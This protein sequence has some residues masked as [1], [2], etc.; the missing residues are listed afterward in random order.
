MTRLPV[1]LAGANTAA[2]LVHGHLEALWR[3]RT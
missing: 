1:P 2:D 3:Q